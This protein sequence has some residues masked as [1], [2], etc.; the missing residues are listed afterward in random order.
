MQERTR[1]R[2]EDSEFEEGIEMATQHEKRDPRYNAPPCISHLHGDA[3]R[4]AMAERDKARRDA[5]M[6]EFRRI[7]NPPAIIRFLD[8]VL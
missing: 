3:R 2:R 5:H 8:R 1:T 7:S 4:S 6:A